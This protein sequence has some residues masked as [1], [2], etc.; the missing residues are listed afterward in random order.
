M[1]FRPYKLAIIGFGTVGEGVY[2]TLNKKAD[3]LKALLERPLDIPIILVK[4][5]D[6]K[7]NVKRETKVTTS[8]SEVLNF[9]SLDVVVEATPDAE[10]GYP[11]VTELLRRGISVITANKELIAKHGLELNKLA[12][13]HGAH[14]LFEAAVA[15]GIP[16]LNTLSHCLKTNTIS[17][18]E[19]ILNGTSNYML[20]KMRTEEASFEK[21]LKEAQEKGY[22]EATPDKD[23]DG[24]DAYFKTTILSH[25]IYGKTPIWTEQHPRGIREVHLTDI[26]LAEEMSGRIKHVASLE[27]IGSYIHASAEPCLV[28]QDNPLY[29]VEGVNN[30]IYIEGSILGSLLLQGAGAGKY[31]TSSAIAE[32]L[33]NLLKNKHNKP[34]EKEIEFTNHGFEQTPEERDADFR[35]Y[36]L[37]GDKDLPEKLRESGIDLLQERKGAMSGSIIFTSL[38]QLDINELKRFNVNV[39]PVL[40]NKKETFAEK[41]NNKAQPV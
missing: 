2:E 9:D 23:V 24:W 7:R 39:Y 33:V 32:D 38:K 1:N 19:A 12:E 28:L 5:K 6:K 25:W 18:I 14:L 8:F 40:T 21:A 3:K 37:T 20:T 17:K 26:K 11:Y 16:L 31:P 35:L 15:G 4:D 29:S 36:F 27:K 10:I 41:Q 30:G 13:A 22:A 34:T